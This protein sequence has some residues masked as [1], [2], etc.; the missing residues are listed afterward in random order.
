MPKGWQ[1]SKKEKAKFVVTPWEVR[2]EVDYEKL[3]KKFGTQPIDE[4]LLHRIERHAGGLHLFLRRGIFFSHRDLDWILDM[5][6][7]GEGFFLYT[8]RGPSGHTHLGHLIP[9]IF[10]KHLQDV[11]G[12]ELYFQLTDD[13]KFLVKR[14]LSIEDVTG[15]SYE[16]ALDVIACGFDPKKTFI[17]SDFGYAKTIY[18]LAVQVARHVTFST[19]KAVFGFTG[20]S[21]I[22]IVFFPAI[23]AVPCFLPSVLKGKN[24]P[25]LIPAAIDQDPYWR[26]V[27]RYVAPKLGF[28]KPAQ[29][30]CKFL[31]GLGPGGKMSASEP[32][33]SIFTTDTKESIEAKIM[34]A[35]TGGQP[36][37]KEQKEKGGNPSVCSIFQ[38][39][40]YL[41]EEDDEKLRKLYD[42]CKTGGIFCGECKKRLA[43]RVVKFIEGH[44]ERRERARS[45]LEDFMLKD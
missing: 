4:G 44:Q 39:Y 5:Y 14:E 23:Q 36:T 32:E 21:N 11:F 40:Y 12:S 8:G 33:T 45:K 13:E 17:F 3:V 30:H 35:F 10:T 16:N 38:Y 20:E 1:L 18:K 28:Y 41:F 15:F 25:C 43:E 7:K 26:G 19:A 22:G 42:G 29:I 27:A 31:P 2:G 6:E 34:N 37:L 9:W 24:I